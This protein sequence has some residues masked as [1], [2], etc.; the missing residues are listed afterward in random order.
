MK[1]TTEQSAILDFIATSDENLMIRA[2]AGCGKSS[3]LK[4]ID[5]TL[6]GT[7]LVICFNKSIADEARKS[8]E[9]RSTKTI[10]TMNSIGHT[11]WADYCHR[12]LV[13]DT[14]KTFTLYKEIV[15]NADRSER[16]HLWNL[17][18]Q[19]RAAVDMARSLGYIPASHA[20]ASRSIAT[21]HEVERR[22]DE[23]PLA[24]VHSL[25]DEVLIRSI[26]LGFS[27]TI[28]FADQCYLPALFRFMKR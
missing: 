24:E 4:L 7:A 18:D 15:D 10:K 26:S 27:G 12:R 2:R 19:V 14:K 8:G 5:A 22:L 21:W 9:F 3:T 28:D 25:V 20:R 16:N 11:I 6:R 17:W 23:T 1:P 13:L